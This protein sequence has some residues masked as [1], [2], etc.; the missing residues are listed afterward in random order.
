[1]T[2]VWKWVSHLLF[3]LCCFG[4]HRDGTRVLERG[5]SEA[6]SQ[7]DFCTSSKNA[8]GD[9]ETSTKATATW[10]KYRRFKRGAVFFDTLVQKSIFRPFKFSAIGVLL[11]WG[12]SRYIVVGRKPCFFVIWLDDMFGDLERL[13]RVGR[14]CFSYRISRSCQNWCFL[15]RC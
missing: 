1:M 6:S 4:L 7:A 11:F 9:N 3:R 8:I 12:W 15:N 10:Q 14:W 2:K 13:M 5:A